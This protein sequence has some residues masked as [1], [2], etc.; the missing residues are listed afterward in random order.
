MSTAVYGIFE[1]GGA[2][3]LAHVA[4]VAAAEQ[5]DLEFIGVAGASAGALIAALVAVGY[6]AESLFDPNN[7]QANVLTRHGISP[8]SLLDENDWERFKT[9]Q[10]KLSGGLWSKLTAWSAFRAAMKTIANRGYFG[11]E[12]IR[13]KLNYLLRVK[14]QDHHARA[15]RVVNLPDR[16]RFRDMDP[17]QVEECCSLKII[18]TDITSQ[19]PVIFGTSPDHADV[20]VA[21][22]VAASIS[23]PFVFKPA[24]I[25]SYAKAPEA[26]YVDGGLVSNMPIWVFAEEKLDYERTSSPKARVPILAFSLVNPRT[27][28]DAASDRIGDRLGPYVAAVL[29]SGIFGGQTVVNTFVPDLVPLPIPVDLRTTEFEFSQQRALNTYYNA[30]AVV[31]G[32]L[33]REMRVKPAQIKTVLQDFYSDA[34]AG[35]GPASAASPVK[36]L[37]LCLIE[38][39]GTRSFRIVHSFNMDND[40]DDRLVF[41]NLVQGAP[42]AFFDKSPAYIDFA[43]TLANG[44]NPNMTK[45][46]LALVRQKLKSAICLPVFDEP[47][48]WSEPVA[49]SR[50]KPLGV[51][52]IDSDDSLDHIFGNRPLLQSLALL[53]LRLK[54]AFKP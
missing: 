1:G 53:S 25:R 12:I 22:V 29:R 15:G 7:P 52:S 31:G 24:N 4:G 45:Y 42:A 19:R 20:E 9:A 51:V 34:L 32:N 48:A 14:L 11:T 33:G 46:E 18:V 23:I 17:E 40:A 21:E 35:I 37:R 27:D 44:A 36:H 6:T 49:A 38:P 54:D 10:R 43:T 47:K 5:N 26:L 13:E 2:K 50:P 16:I 3:G 30:F 28:D 8:L 39:F 41:S